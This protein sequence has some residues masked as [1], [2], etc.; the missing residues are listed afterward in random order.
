MA[1]LGFCCA[2]GDSEDRDRT[3]K[4]ALIDKQLAREKDKLRSTYKIL[5]L[6]SAESGKSTVMKQMRIINGKD[7]L[8]EEVLQYKLTIYH[9]IVKG[10][11]VLVDACNKLQLNIS[12]PE[13]LQHA[14]FVFSYCNSTR[15]NEEMFIQ[16]KPSVTK[17]WQDKGIQ[18]AFDRRKEFHLVRQVFF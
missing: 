14:D 18:E 12:Q 4:S 9:N 6:G 13:N 3:M 1:D 11:K 15:L 10:M 16:Y 2:S 8:P 17:L 5:L 7:F